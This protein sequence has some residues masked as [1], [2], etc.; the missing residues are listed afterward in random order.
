MRN[1]VV[2]ALIACLPFSLGALAA[3]EITGV[4]PVVMPDTPSGV[5]D[6]R[7]IVCRAPQRFADSNQFGPKSCGYNYE[8]W[9]LTTQGKDLAP[10]GKTVI[11]RPVVANPDG[12]GNPDAVTCRAPRQIAGPSLHIRHFGP[13][14]CQTNQ[15]WADLN[16]NYK[17]V[18]ARGVVV[19][20]PMPIIA[21]TSTYTDPL[22][23]YRVGGP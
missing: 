9:Q 14:V 8:W 5:G 13:E 20:K 18:D 17:F 15:F 1:A 11:D 3:P 12:K 4:D 22:A 6:P 23:G 16:K 19:R 21:P 2:G 10:D 7:A